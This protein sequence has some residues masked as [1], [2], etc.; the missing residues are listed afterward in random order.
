M[1]AQKF[2]KS[3]YLIVVFP[4]GTGGNHIQNMISLSPVFNKL[5]PSNSYYNDLLYNYNGL[6]DSVN[7]A[8]VTAHF[9]P[10]PNLYGLEDEKYR[11]FISTSDKKTIL[12]GHNHCI[13]DYVQRKLFVDFRD[14]VWMIVNWP[15]TTDCLVY[16][17]I[18]AGNYLPQFS[19]LYKFPYLVPTSMH[20]YIDDSRGFNIDPIKIFAANGSDYLRKMLREKLDLELPKEADNLHKIW[21]KSQIDFMSVYDK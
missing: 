9:N 5:F 18:E 11:D 14:C 6:K 12:V 3:K 16:K 17:R 1:L 2:K 8:G 7:P 15:Q 10:H 19:E 20:Y 4:G 21:F 13:Q